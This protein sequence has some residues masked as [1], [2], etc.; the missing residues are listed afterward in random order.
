[1]TESRSLIATSIFLA[2]TAVFARDISKDAVSLGVCSQ[3]AQIRASTCLALASSGAAFNA[4]NRKSRFLVRSTLGSLAGASGSF[5]Y[6]PGGVGGSAC[7]SAGARPAV[8]STR[9][10]YKVRAKRNLTAMVKV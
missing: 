9:A 8:P 6:L 5:F 10:R 4:P 3:I 1:M 2:S 7:A